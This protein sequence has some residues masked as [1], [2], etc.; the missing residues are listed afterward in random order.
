MSSF[1][2]LGPHSNN[3]YLYIDSAMKIPFNL[4]FFIF[5]I[6]LLG[7]VSCNQGGGSSSGGGEAVV[8]E[9]PIGPDL[10]G[11]TWQGYFRNLT[12]AYTALS[13]TIFH[14]GNRVIIDT[15]LPDTMSIGRFQGTISSV[16][17]LLLIDSFDGEDWTTLYG[18]ASVNSINL[19]DFV[20]TEG[21]NVDTNIIILKR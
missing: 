20:F 1:S 15:S 3:Q 8:L 18:P 4:K 7:L 21:S 9:P 17:G 16:G 14:E 19:A 13:A 2:K 5:P 11:D 6:L 10:N 12:G